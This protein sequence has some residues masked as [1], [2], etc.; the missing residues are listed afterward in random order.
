M[1]FESKKSIYIFVIGNEIN[2]SLFLFI[3]QMMDIIVDLCARKW[4]NIKIDFFLTIG[5]Y[6]INFLKL[7]FFLIS[8]ALI[9]RYWWPHW[10]YSNMCRVAEDTRA[11]DEVQ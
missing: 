2:Y 10:V 5:S 7:I 3:L 4:Y 1:G 8:F 11:P 6:R 9:W